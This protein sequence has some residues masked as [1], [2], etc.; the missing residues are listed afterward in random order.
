MIKE[1]LFLLFNRKRFIALAM[2]RSDQIVREQ[3]E[4]DH[5]RQAGQLTE[6]PYFETQTTT[7]RKAVGYSLSL[8][9]IVVLLGWAA[10]QLL[11]CLVGPPSQATAR[12]ILYS[13]IGTLLW[14]TLAKCGWNIQSWNGTT[15]PEQVDNFLFRFLYLVGSFL[16]VLSG[17]WSASYW[18]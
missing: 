18:S 12:L 10:G 1:T 14:A 7:L 2:Q 15:L 13:G 17:T 5:R 6:V 16:L 3:Q 11:D 8:V 4:R 9:L